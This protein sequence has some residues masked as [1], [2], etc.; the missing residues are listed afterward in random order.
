MLQSHRGQ[1]HVKALETS[2]C[3][4]L[5]RE[6]PQFIDIPGEQARQKFSLTNRNCYCAKI[7]LSRV[8][9]QHKQP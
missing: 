9:S 6:I 4:W 2:H 1:D 8:F 5:L 3:Y 7:V